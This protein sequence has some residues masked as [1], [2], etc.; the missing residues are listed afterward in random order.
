MPSFKK[1]LRELKAKSTY[2]NNRVFAVFQFSVP[3]SKKA[4]SLLEK[5]RGTFVLSQSH[6]V[7]FIGTEEQENFMKKTKTL[8]AVGVSDVLHHIKKGGANAFSTLL[9]NPSAISKLSFKD[10][11]RLCFLEAFPSYGRGSFIYQ[12]SMQN[13]DMKALYNVRW[14]SSHT[15]SIPIGLLDE[16]VITL[17]TQW[18]DICAQ[19]QELFPPKDY[20][21]ETQ[22]LITKQGR[23][24]NI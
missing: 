20:P 24:D 1:S 14:N 8:K 21:V 17:E 5:L 16:D 18:N 19:R 13:T 2:H 9:V 11:N 23:T 3:K 12:T 22:Y 10:R 15:I 4:R 6:K 7:G